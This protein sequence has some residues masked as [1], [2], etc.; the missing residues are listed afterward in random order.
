MERLPCLC[1]L[2]M[3]EE[4]VTTMLYIFPA[5]VET[6]EYQLGNNTLNL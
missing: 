1:M 3:H 2:I 5:A 6:Q 4:E